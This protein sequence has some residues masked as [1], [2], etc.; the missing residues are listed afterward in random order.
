MAETAK[1]HQPA[2][3]KDRELSNSNFSFMKKVGDKPQ[4][5]ISKPKSTAS[6]SEPR[7]S[8]GRPPLSSYLEPEPTEE[9][10]FSSQRIEENYP[11][12]G[13]LLKRENGLMK[14]KEVI[15]RDDPKD[16]EYVKSRYG[17]GAYQLRL[18][19][20]ESEEKIDFT[21]SG[22]APVEQPEPQKKAIDEAFIAG[23]RREI[24]EEIRADYDDIVSR[25]EKRLRNKDDE[26]D[27][28]SR[29]V[30][31]LNSEL[32]ETERKAA[33]SI[34]EDSKEFEA[35]I[36]ALKED[37]RDLEFA[38]FE[39]EQELKYAD[40]EG[41]FDLKGMLQDAAS[42]PQLQQLLTPILAK[43]FGGQP[44]P[45]QTAALADG[46]RMNPSEQAQQNPT[47]EPSAPISEQ[48]EQPTE[49]E[50]MQ[51]LVNKF[52]S[53]IV[54][55]AASS[56]ATGNPTSDNL[57]DFVLQQVKA[58]KANGI[59]PQPGMWIGISKALVEVAL[60]NSITAEKAAQTIKPILE[61]FNGAANSLKFIPAK[62][63]AQAL[64]SQFNIDV[65][66]PQKQ[67]LIE[68]LKVFKKQL[69]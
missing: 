16:A 49:Q 61:Q 53:S 34:R 31:N 37:K 5:T 62:G 15:T 46:H 3:E 47:A 57:K 33:K 29:K 6:P 8:G 55:T 2:F 36:E 4:E 12:F 10:A 20:A 50:Q 30:R 42:N 45:A 52:T 65:T 58:L 60:Q 22:V 40:R 43:I 27:E 24:K 69:K 13:T 59:Q 1:Y 7:H 51:H 32:A 28:Y 9:F 39:L 25:L 41:G 48:Q 19:T 11:F 21:V 38:V 14:R 26:L 64:I 17:G 66:E 56:M 54:Q 35:K 68:V 44:S 23:L 18:K 67:F 63:A